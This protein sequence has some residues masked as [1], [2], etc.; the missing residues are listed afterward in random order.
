[1][2]TLIVIVTLFVSVSVEAREIVVSEDNCEALGANAALWVYM[3]KNNVAKNE[4]DKKDLMDS[5]GRAAV[6]CETYEA[7]FDQGAKKLIK[8]FKESGL[9]SDVEIS[10]FAMHL[11][12]EV[13]FTD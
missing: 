9:S 11:A 1:M 2:K 7:S 13:Y 8:W 5:A 10:R 6:A 3:A 12:S 4:V